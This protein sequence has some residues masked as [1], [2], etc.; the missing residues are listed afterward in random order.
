MGRSRH[1]VST[2]TYSGRFAVRLR[3]LREKTGMTVEEMSEKTGVSI[4]TLY[5][6]ENASRSPV[7]DDLLHV[8]QVLNVN[9]RTLLPKE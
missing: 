2:S 8:A 9:V 4:A 1:E 7:N 5:S 6:W 3:M